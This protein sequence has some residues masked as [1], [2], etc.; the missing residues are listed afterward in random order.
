MVFFPSYRFLEQVYEEFF[1]M[2]EGQT[3]CIVQTTGMK[4]EEQG[5]IF[6]E[7]EKRKKTFVSRFLRYGRNLWRRDRFEKRNF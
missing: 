4:E 3:D 7:F 2:M 6:R 1:P 5:R